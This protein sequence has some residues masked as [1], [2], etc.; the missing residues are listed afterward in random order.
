MLCLSSFNFSR[1]RHGLSC[2]H[3]SVFEPIRSHYHVYV[4]LT[5]RW[6]FYY[7]LCYT[8][9][10]R[11]NQLE[12]AVHV[13]ILL[14]RGLVSIMSLACK[15]STQ[16]D[17]PCSYFSYLFSFILHSDC[18]PMFR[19]ASARI[20]VL[21]FGSHKRQKGRKQNRNLSRNQKKLLT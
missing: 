8:V 16:S 18:V 7:L 3:T 6:L 13:F 19:T 11:A 2:G 15:F 9:L 14:I 1:Q 21:R 10:T 4:Q 12:T 5:S 17:Q 20:F